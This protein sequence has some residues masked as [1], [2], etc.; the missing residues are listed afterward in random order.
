[1]QAQAERDEAQMRPLFKAAFAEA[2]RRNWNRTNWSLGAAPSWISPEEDS[3]DYR[4][5]GGTVWTSL[6]YGFEGVPGLENTSQ[7]ILH[8]RYRNHE[9]VPDPEKEGAFRRQDSLAGGARLRMGSVDTNCSLDAAYIREWN[10][11]EDTSA[12]RV[13]LG[14]ERR[15]TNNLWLSLSFGKEFGNEERKDPLLILGTFK[16]GY[17]DKPTSISPVSPSA[18]PVVLRTPARA[19]AAPVE[20]PA[21]V[22]APA[23]ETRSR[24]R[25]TAATRV[26]FMPRGSATEKSRRPSTPD[27]AREAALPDG[28]SS[29]AIEKVRRPSTPAGARE[30]TLPGESPGPST[31]GKVKRPETPTGAR[32]A[33]LPDEKPGS[34]VPGKAKRPTTPTGAREAVLPADPAASSTPG[35]TKRPAT[36]AGARDATLPNE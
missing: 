21:A 8:A 4:W 10:D 5:N 17:A 31:T 28:K 30:A 35:K 26:V 9:E 18:A 32:E 11:Q 6:A 33:T 25:A 7:L 1:M 2:R 16:L 36:P 15:M 22:P 13:S 34:A 23:V 27:N 12:Y 29:S 3:G 19:S 14:V 24:S 20:P